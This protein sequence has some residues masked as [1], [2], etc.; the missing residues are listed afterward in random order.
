VLALLV[1]AAVVAFVLLR[2]GDEGGAA[3]THP[4][5]VTETNAICAELERKNRALD[6]P[7]RPYGTE[8]EP[9]FSSFLDNVETAWNALKDLEPPS[10]DRSAFDAL[11]KGYTDVR[12]SLQEAQAAAATDQDPE[13]AAVIGE[14]DDRTRTMV[15]TERQLGVCPG[16]TSVQVA[17]TT[18][19]KRTVPNPLEQSGTLGG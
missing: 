17:V 4:A 19:L 3:V 11:V 8:S 14:I 12:L 15:P 7:F 10:A 18:L 16:K 2:G 13:V 5:L 9:Y 1:V 6:P